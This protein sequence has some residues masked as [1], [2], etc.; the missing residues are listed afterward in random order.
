MLGQLVL[1]FEPDGVGHARGHVLVRLQIDL[2]SVGKLQHPLH[3]KPLIDGPEGQKSSDCSK[4]I[5]F[6]FLRTW[7]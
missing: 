4:K 7:K 1:E 5:K 3:V 2:L 6:V